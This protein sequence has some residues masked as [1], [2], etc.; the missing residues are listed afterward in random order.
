MSL[1]AK[2]IEKGLG[3]GAL[4]EPEVLSYV[5]VET[6]RLRC[7]Q[8][9]DDGDQ[10]AWLKAVHRDLGLAAYHLSTEFSPEWREQYLA[11]ARDASDCG[12]APA[13]LL[14]C[15]TPGDAPLPRR[16]PDRQRVLRCMFEEAVAAAHASGQAV[17][18]SP[19][20]H[21]RKAHV[22][23]LAAAASLD[24]RLAD[25]DPMAADAA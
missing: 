21:L 23:A 10:R 7:E 12:P 15:D 8:L 20:Q 3:G 4:P 22:H 6:A 9:I 24:R 18:E 1:R 25:D 2:H 19:A 11:A 5:L 13:G 14:E 16:E 17:A